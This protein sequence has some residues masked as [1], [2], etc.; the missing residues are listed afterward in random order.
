M[1]NLKMKFK[2]KKNEKRQ[3]VIKKNGEYV[4]ELVGR[5]AS[6]EV[7]GAIVASDNEEVIVDIKTIHKAPE[8]QSNLFIRAVVEDRAKVKLS[9][10]IKIEE[11]AQKTDALLKENI[12]LLSNKAKAE[13]IP[14]LEIEADD[15]KCSHAATI[16]KISTNLSFRSYAIER[17]IVNSDCILQSTV[18]QHVNDSLEST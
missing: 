18:S 9:G 16:G 6:V 4:V 17:Y 5:G 7:L 3:I 1:K 2:I 15:V 10:L 12:L 13:A 14:N 11:K 8:T